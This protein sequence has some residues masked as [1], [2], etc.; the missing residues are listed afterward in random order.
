MIEMALKNVV[1]M[2]EIV[3]KFFAAKSQKSPVAAPSVIRLS[4]ICLFSTEPKLDNFSAKKVL[5]L[6]QAPFLLAKSWLLLWSHLLLQTDF[7]R[8]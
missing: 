1:N 7:L 4:C 5:L 6:F 8:G 3:L 2:T